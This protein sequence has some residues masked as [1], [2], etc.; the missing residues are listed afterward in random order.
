MAQNKH[1]F[2]QHFTENLNYTGKNYPDRG[3]HY[4]YK[5]IWEFIISRA[6]TRLV[7]DTNFGES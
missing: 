4:S 6:V 3:I 7:I 1:F 2:S 5:I